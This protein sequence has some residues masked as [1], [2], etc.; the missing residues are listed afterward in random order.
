MEDAALDAEYSKTVEESQ[1]EML[2]TGFSPSTGDADLELRLAYTKAGFPPTG[3]NAS[4]Y[5]NPDVDNYVQQGLELVD[6][7]QRKEAYAKAQELIMED[8]PNIFLYAP[9]YFGAIRDD[10][11]G[12]ST[13][14][15]GVVYMRTA[16]F[17]Q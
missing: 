10:A 5:D 16:Y 15:D 17:K 1:K 11:G 4:F 3:F 2:M 9:T 8:A 12:V 13:Q 7:D 14:A 6:P